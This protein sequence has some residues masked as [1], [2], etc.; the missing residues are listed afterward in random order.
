MN[1]TTLRN[2]A[3]VVGVILFVP[4]F[5]ISPPFAVI[6]VVIVVGAWYVATQIVGN[7][8]V[9]VKK[10]GQTDRLYKLWIPVR[11]EMSEVVRMGGKVT[12]SLSVWTAVPNL[13]KQ[14]TPATFH[15]GMER[16]VNKRAEVAALVVGKTST[17]EMWQQQEMDQ[18]E[19]LFMSRELLEEAR[20]GVKFLSGS[21]QTVGS[22]RA[23][24][25]AAK[26]QPT[27]AAATRPSA[28]SGVGRQRSS[29]VSRATQ[30]R[31]STPTRT[32]PTRPAPSRPA[33]STMR[34][35]VESPAPAPPQITAAPEPP[36]PVVAAPA[37][38]EPEPRPEPAAAPV[39]T[40]GVASVPEVV[41]ETRPPEP[42]VVAPPPD[43]KSVV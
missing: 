18:Q 13:Y 21:E 36:G 22:E 16:Y 30:A 37:P 38:R 40:P 35:A 19:L 32:T 14:E 8:E 10:E 6:L 9:S 41:E 15:Q 7:S 11:D 34:S 3:I 33:P 39:S 28:A 24:R 25:A 26:A 12:S 31:P 2:I 29:A 1:K 23:S 27:R 4:A 5:V 20:K 42:A 43:R 17:E